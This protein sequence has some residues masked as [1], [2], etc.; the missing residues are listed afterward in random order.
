MERIEA[1]LGSRQ[2]CLSL[3]HRVRQGDPASVLAAK[4]ALASIDDPL[5]LAE[6]MEFVYQSAKRELETDALLPG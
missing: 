5:V 6:I 2:E 1:I 4:L 3:I